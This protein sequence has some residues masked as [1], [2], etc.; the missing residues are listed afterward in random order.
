MCLQLIDRVNVMVSDVDTLFIAV[1]AT[2]N[3]N[4]LNPDR[5]ICRYELLEAV[6]RM[7]I[8]KYARGQLPC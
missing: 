1:N 6:V 3:R 7:A 4:K 5:S 8:L 2:Q